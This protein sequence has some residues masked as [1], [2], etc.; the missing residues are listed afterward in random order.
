MHR[1]AQWLI[2]A[3]SL[4]SAAQAQST[5]GL[6]LAGN[7]YYTGEAMFVDGFKHSQPFF[8]Q[9]NGAGWSQSDP[10]AVIFGADGYPTTIAADHTT[11]SLWDVPR[12]HTGGRHVLLWDGN[13]DV[14]IMFAAG[15]QIVLNSAG[16]DCGRLAAN[17][18]PNQ[19]PWHSQSVRPP[20]QSGPQHSPG[21][22]RTGSSLFKRPTDKPLP[23]RVSRPLGNDGLVPLHGLDRD[24]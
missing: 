15:G 24:Q 19:S 6:N 10:G 7:A 18:R 11:T 13:G 4:C 16:S 9:K 14:S 20:E 1:Y 8:P 5:I 17:Q 2:L 12:G 3:T 22:P 21:A 23:Q